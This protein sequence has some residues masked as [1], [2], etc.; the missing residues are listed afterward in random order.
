MR[1]R[2]GVDRVRQAAPAP[3][4]GREDRTH[5]LRLASRHD[6]GIERVAPQRIDRGVA[7]GVGGGDAGFVSEIAGGPQRRVRGRQ[8]IAALIA[9]GPV[10]DAVHH[11]FGLIVVDPALAGRDNLVDA[12][13]QSGVNASTCLAGCSRPPARRPWRGPR[14]PRQALS[15]P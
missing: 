14:P 1:V 13:L 15:Q 12:V 2:V 3:L 4:D 8:S 11:P 9:G 10:E 6:P 7:P 5:A